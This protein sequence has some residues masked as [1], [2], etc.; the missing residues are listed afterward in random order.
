[1]GLIGAMVRQFECTWNSRFWQ[2]FYAN[3]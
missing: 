3:T 2:R 1:M